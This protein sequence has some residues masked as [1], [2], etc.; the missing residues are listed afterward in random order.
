MHRHRSWRG[1]SDCENIQKSVKKPENQYKLATGLADSLPFVVFGINL[2]ENPV[3]ELVISGGYTGM[4]GTQLQP[5]ANHPQ[6]PDK[7][8]RSFRKHNRKHDTIVV[9]QIAHLCTKCLSV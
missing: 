6:A 2:N 8:F 4:E 9:S 5:S 3:K 7:Q 1:N